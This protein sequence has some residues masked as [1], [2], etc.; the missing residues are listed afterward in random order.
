MLSSSV[1]A[2]VRLHQ[3]RFI[4][5]PDFME[6]LA[7][8]VRMRGGEVRE[9]VAATKI[10]DHDQEGVVVTYAGLFTSPTSGWRARR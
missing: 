2:A 7:E 3:Q 10:S 1:R 5:P 4:D 9:G 8:A 6:A